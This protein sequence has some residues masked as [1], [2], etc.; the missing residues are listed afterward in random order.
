MNAHR[1]QTWYLDKVFNTE[2]FDD[3]KN[4][5]NAIGFSI[6]ELITIRYLIENKESVTCNT[7]SSVAE[8]D[9]HT[10]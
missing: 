7:Y 1:F 2:K 9:T 8:K 6:K 5:A 10:R 3:A 4:Y